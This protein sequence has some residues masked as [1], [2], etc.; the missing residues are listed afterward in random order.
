MDDKVTL[1]ICTRMIIMPS[2]TVVAQPGV[3]WAGKKS[4]FLDLAQLDQRNR[5]SKM[6]VRGGRIHPELHAQRPARLETR[7]QLLLGKD[8]HHAAPQGRDSAAVDTLRAKAYQNDENPYVRVK[9]A[10][11]LSNIHP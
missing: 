9:A 5:V 4:R 6:N 11:A 8:A 10:E 1:K 7:E 2:E 3:A